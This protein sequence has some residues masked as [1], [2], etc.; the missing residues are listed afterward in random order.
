MRWLAL[1]FTLIRP[2]P[3]CQTATVHLGNP[4]DFRID[5][6]FYVVPKAVDAT[7]RP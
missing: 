7:S 5:D 2:T 6:H 3:M 1:A 4:F